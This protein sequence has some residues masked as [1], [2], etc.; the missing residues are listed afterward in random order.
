M[1]LLRMQLVFCCFSAAICTLL[2]ELSAL[3]GYLPSVVIP[4][5]VSAAPARCLAEFAFCFLP[6]NIARTW[7]Y[8]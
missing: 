7:P 5:W 3:L 1:L 2:T 4:S 8:N 6:Q